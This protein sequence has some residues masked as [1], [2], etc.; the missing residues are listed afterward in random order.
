MRRPRK[1][2]GLWK[3]PPLTTKFLKKKKAPCEQIVTRSQAYLIEVDWKKQFLSQFSLPCDLSYSI[4]SE[5][6]QPFQ[7]PVLLHS[8]CTSLDFNIP[9]PFTIT[10]MFKGLNILQWLFFIH[11]WAKHM[12]PRQS[13]G[14]KYV[15]TLLRNSN[16]SNLIVTF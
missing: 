12:N 2:L 10:F 8:C 15:L 6:S 11:L 16:Q 5:L 3:R 1:P 14:L 13:F 9:L 4:W 7:S